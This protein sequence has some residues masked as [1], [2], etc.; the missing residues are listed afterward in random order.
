MARNGSGTYS[1]PAGNPVTTGAVISSTWANNTLDDIATAL[2][3]SLAKD[4]Q[5][6]PTANLPMATYKHTGVGTATATT[7]YAR[8]DQVQNSALQYL[9]SVSGA[10]TIT[11]SA[12]ITPAAYAAGQTFRFISAGANTGAA[13][14]NV[15]S[16]GAK[17]IKKQGTNALAAGDIAS[18]ALVEVTYDG[19]NFQL[20]TPSAAASISLS[21]DNTWTGIQSF[22]QDL[23][24]TGA[25]KGVIFEGTTADAYET[26]LLA[27]EPTADRTI[28]MPDETGTVALDGTSR[29]QTIWIPANAMKARTTNGAATGSTELTTNK[30]MI[31]TLDFDATTAEY[32][33]FSINMPKS[34]DEGT[35]TA[36]FVWSHAATT[37]NFG[38]AWELAAVAFADDDAMDTAFGTAVTVTD[39]GGTTNDCYITAASSAMTV[40]G[41]PGANELVYFQVNR[42]P[43]NGSDTMAI[44]ARLHGVRVMYAIN[45]LTDA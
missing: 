45:T 44:D 32:A 8:A 4:G 41:S 29:T 6:T 24:I 20:T 17:S 37:T 42:A 38:V 5:T 18:G 23:T 13:T 28:T 1:L 12:S 40:A 9:S 22:T 31:E 30:E 14:L 16:L 39:T 35:M 33:Q 27:G 10:D 11:A 21:D 2:T 34:W 43:S 26:T 36:V 25:G 19:T 3:A 7:D 15:S